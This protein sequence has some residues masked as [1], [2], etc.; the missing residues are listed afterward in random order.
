MSNAA[1]RVATS[2]DIEAPT[3]RDV[4]AWANGPGNSSL[5][6]MER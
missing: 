1:M 2:Y 4:I 5:K 3:A 6:I